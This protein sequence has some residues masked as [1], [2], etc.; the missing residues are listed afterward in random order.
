M[1]GPLHFAP[2]GS[3]DA[4][5]ISALQRRL[6]AAEL[7]E[8]EAHIAG[9]LRNT[10][11]HMVCNMSYGLFDGTQ[12]VG[13]VFAYVESE[14]L[15]HRR[16]EELIY[17]KEIALLPGYEGQMRRLFSRLFMQWLAFT[18]RLSLEA[19]ALGPA[20]ENW[21]RLERAF[22]FYGLTLTTREET[23]RAGRPAYRLMRMDLA[24]A[25]QK[26][27]QRPSP[28][29]AAG[30]PLGYGLDARI[31]TSPR[32]WLGLAERWEELRK[33][34]PGASAQQAFP[35][36]WEWWK[37][38]GIWSDLHLVVFSKGEAVVGIAPLMLEHVPE[39]DV[40]LRR[41]QLLGSPDFVAHGAPV[42]ARDPHALVSLL[43]E[44]L[45]AGEGEWDALEITARDACL[46]AD[47]LAARLRSQGALAQN[48]PRK[49][50]VVT[51][52]GA[53]TTRHRASVR[54]IER[55]YARASVAEMHCAVEDQGGNP[56]DEWPLGDDRANAFF[57]DALAA[58]GIAGARLI[59]H[60]SERDGQI[61][62]SRFGIL[63]EGV[64]RVL[65]AA[66]A[67]GAAADARDAEDAEAVFLSAQGC[68]QIEYASAVP[69][70]ASGV[71]K[72]QHLQVYQSRH[73]QIARRAV[74]RHRLASLVEVFAWRGT[75]QKLARLLR[76][77]V[78]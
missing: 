69:Q 47:E 73:R 71:I 54:R 67:S 11:Q 52:G 9:I 68:G 53:T 3:D 19:H 13:Y 4:P 16:P 58:G 22:R 75:G 10:E 38:H 64:F 50:R 20:L 60:V 42:L 76:Q 72:L 49:L 77:A 48:L 40:V 37:F 1:S 26:L 15:F 43:P 45:A 46:R 74:W 51:P 59:Q 30:V 34:T 62:A 18:P 28:L 39:G 44:A 63:R 12:L 23:P 32:Q 17:L 14:S 24:P 6:F 36:L 33:A 2:L 78:R 56:G 35:E 27:L 29:P 8:S 41:L 55:P 70:R 66:H 57:F 61:V 25:T 31:V 5:L 7:T 65:R 21:R